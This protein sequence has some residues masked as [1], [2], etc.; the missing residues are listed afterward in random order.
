MIQYINHENSVNTCTLD[1]Y[2][3]KLILLMIMA[4]LWTIQF[5]TC[6]CNSFI[7]FVSVLAISND[8]TKKIIL[9]IEIII[10]L[11]ILASNPNV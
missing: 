11:I 1:Y 4:V 8:V 7:N 9:L 6:N 10:I 2:T 5:D 3:Q